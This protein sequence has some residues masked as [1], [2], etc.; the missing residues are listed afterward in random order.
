MLPANCHIGLPALKSRRDDTLL[1][2][3]FNLRETGNM[4]ILQNCRP[5]GTLSKSVASVVRRLKST[6]NRVPSLRD[7]L[8][9]FSLKV[10]SL[11]VLFGLPAVPSLR[12]WLSANRR[13]TIHRIILCLIVLILIVLSLIGCQKEQDYKQTQPRRS[14]L[15]YL[16][17]DNNLH[18]EAEQKISQ[19]KKTWN[20][21]IDG[22]LFVYSDT[23][24]QPFLVNIYY[25]PQRGAVTDTISIHP[26]LNSA[27]PAT[28]AGAMNAVRAFRNADSFGLV[29]L[30]HGTGWLPAEMS[31]PAIRP[32]S[33]IL[34][35]ST[36]QTENYME[37]ATFADAIPYRL[38]FII[39]DACWMASVEAA[40]QL[41]DKTDYIVASSAEILEPGFVY[42]SMMQHLF[43][44][45][46][47]LKAVAREFYEYHNAAPDIFRSAT[48]SV[49]K[50]SELPA[51]RELAKD[52]S[53]QAPIDAETFLPLETLD[54]IQH[55]GHGAHRLFF[56]LG[57]YLRALAPDRS[58]DVDAALER[59]VPYRASTPQYYSSAT[60]AL[61]PIK[62]FSGLTVYIPQEAY[63]KTNDAHQNLRW[64][65][66]FFH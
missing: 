2:V 15:V 61:E 30:S 46:P 33:I 45:A 14:V 27:L 28:L 53:Q 9:V 55:F 42:G 16:G 43:K 38:D 25:T 24:E 5:C 20:K 59:S 32:K 41:K 56:D 63:P 34:D 17:V 21:D 64:T 26:N 31:T 54:N 1:T 10:F 8:Q 37:I 51:L 12:D 47:D 60:G 23:G 65:K 18:S 58:N 36:D 22:N 44:P 52:I 40:Y 29:V 39:F 3:D 6:V 62:A 48:V 7:W 13:I 19:L 66:D 4:R 11:K 35:A 57:D 50:T 49:I